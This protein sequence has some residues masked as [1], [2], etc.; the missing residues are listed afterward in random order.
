MER[1]RITKKHLTRLH[2]AGLPHFRL[3]AHVVRYD[4]ISAEQ[5]LRSREQEAHQ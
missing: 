5:W 1:W 2:N 3:S 4:P